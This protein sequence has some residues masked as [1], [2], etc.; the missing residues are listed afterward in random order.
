MPFTAVVEAEAVSVYRPD[1]IC[2]L[3]TPDKKIGPAPD[4]IGSP[5]QADFLVFQ[6]CLVCNKLVLNFE[7]K[8]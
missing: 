1:V 7:G 3:M 2:M 6:K 8:L 4:E 5:W